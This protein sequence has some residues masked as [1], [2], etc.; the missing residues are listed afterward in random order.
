MNWF[1]KNR[2]LGTFLILFGLCMLGAIWFLSGAKSNWNEASTRLNQTAAEL[3]RLERLA[4]YPSAENLRKM[5]V[6]ADNYATALAKLKDKLK[7]RVAPVPPM[8]PNEFQSHLRLAMTAIADKARANKVKIPD[9]FYLGFDEF[10]SALPNEVAAPLLGQELVQVEWLLNSVLDAHVEALT[11]FHRTP[12]P[13]EHGVASA[14]PGPT[15]EA[16]VKPAG[17]L[18]TGPKL[19]ERNVVQATFISTPATARKVLN[20]IAGA[21][22]QFCIIRLLH[23]RNEKEKGPSREV[24]PEATAVVPAT[25]AP[26][27][28]PAGSPGE[29]VGI[30]PALYFIVGN[31]RIETTAEVEIVRFTF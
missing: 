11:S 21:N 16:G 3:N 12:L 30:G 5:E 4:P 6:H 19:L 23:V 18:P 28:A 26:A 13:E 22:Q 20:E 31:E 8:A 7:V 17:T 25:P 24:A 29:K 27:P 1:R 14:S 9:K 15:P 10:A 2:F